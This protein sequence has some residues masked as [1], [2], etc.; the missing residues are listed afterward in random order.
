VDKLVAKGDDLL[1][2]ADPRGHLRVSAQGLSEAASPI[3][4]NLRS[5][6]ARSMAS[7]W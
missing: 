4:S 1:V 2:V 7:F 3:T 5:T 6:A